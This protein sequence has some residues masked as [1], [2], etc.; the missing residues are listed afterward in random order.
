M[1]ESAVF[2][3]KEVPDCVLPGSIQFALSFRSNGV[4]KALCPGNCL[5][6]LAANGA[7]VGETRLIGLQLE[8]LS[9]Y[10]AD[11]DWKRHDLNGKPGGFIPEAQ[12]GAGFTGIETTELP[13]EGRCLARPLQS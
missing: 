6:R 3:I 5:F 8:L 7:A 13:D 9:T 4:G 10:G 11:F 12:V 1:N 2:A